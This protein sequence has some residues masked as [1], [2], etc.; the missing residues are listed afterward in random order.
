MLHTI[1]LTVYTE[2][3]LAQDV[4]DRHGRN[5]QSC[6]VHGRNEPPWNQFREKH[7]ETNDARR[8]PFQH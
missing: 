2:G 7:D 6:I 4:N 1:L 8:V 5:L 3:V